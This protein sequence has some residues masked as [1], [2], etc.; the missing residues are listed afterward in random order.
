[1]SEAAHVRGAKG[2]SNRG[3]FAKFPVDF[4]R[5]LKFETKTSLKMSSESPRGGGAGGL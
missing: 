3:L 5:R 2:R 1:M 4:M